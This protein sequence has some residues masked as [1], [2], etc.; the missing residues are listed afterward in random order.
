M[1]NLHNVVMNNQVLSI[2]VIINLAWLGGLTYLW[3]FLRQKY[4]KIFGAKDNED[5]CKV[6]TE[7]QDESKQRSSSTQH[8]QEALN[9]LKRDSQNH[10]QKIGLVRYNPFA[11]TGG[12]QSFVLAVL[13]EKGSGFV[14][15]SLHS[16]ESTRLFAK[17]V[18]DGKESG[19]EF[20]K[21]EIQAI[22]EAKKK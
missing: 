21:E 13:D 2:L 16:R 12:N 15:T 18:V 5:F 1:P 8:L 17:P 7:L 4:G 20:S 3:F 19:Y 9:L 14:V 6:L 22:L 11:D 10:L